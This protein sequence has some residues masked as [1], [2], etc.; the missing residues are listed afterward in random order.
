MR[1]AK[2][3]VR[4]AAAA[5]AVL[6]LAAGCAAIPSSGGVNRGQART[7]ED[8]LDSLELVPEGP[9]KGDTP[10]Q[11]LRGFID[12]ATS[13]R[14]S[15]DVA[16]DFLTGSFEEDWEPG[17]RVTIDVLSSRQL[18]QLGAEPGEDDDRTSMRVRAVP[19]AGLTATG[20]YEIAES[21]API[22]LPYEFRKVNGEWRISDAPQGILID[23]SNFELVFRQHALFFFAPGFDALVPDLR[24]F[25]GADSV[26]TSIVRALLEG[27]SEWLAGG[28]V[29]AVP[30]GMRLEPDAV[31]VA[32]RV[33][34]VELVGGNVD[35]ALAI[36][37]IQLQL[38]ESLRAVRS[39]G[40]VSLTVNGAAN[41]LA[42]LPVPPAPRVDSRTVVFDGE[43]F[44]YLSSDG[45]D[46]ETLPGISE[47]VAAL[48]PVG[49][50]VGPEAQRVAVLSSAGVSLVSRGDPAQTL[51]TRP[52]LVTPAIDE[53]DVVWSVPADEPG[54][55]EWFGGGQHG[56][57]PVPWNAERI[58][59]LEVSRDGTRLLVF[60]ET[61]GHTQLLVAAV[62]RDA[63][64]LPLALGTPVRLDA[65]DGE[66]RDIAWVDARTVVSLTGLS[67]GSGAIITQEVG[68][69]ATRRTAPE[70]AVQVTGGNNV[71]DLR[72]LTSE[73]VLQS[74]AGV[75]W[76]PRATGVAFL[77]PQ[78]RVD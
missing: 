76:Q 70:D 40:E 51:D 1:H 6:A 28:V 9:A 54:A 58:A 45:A 56:T 48:G 13:P 46:V 16:R 64:H 65:V 27:P 63:Q 38:D 25:A 31:P 23:E 3:T 30:E 77:A 60:L 52:G 61:N 26:Q 19:A 57:L 18:E 42:A 43:R 66:A 35:D 39:V 20:Q 5:V 14:N 74:Q 32:G 34:S 21:R 8:P 62:Q 2:R 12:A 53:H 73:G 37:R 71:R 44:G 22:E 68:G 41:D 69:L 17:S 11:I 59:G 29:T 49:A 47:Q 33:A 10:E 4:S 67:D 78:Q 36:Q 72:T 24:W 7:V 55:L 75:G 15:Y 50:A